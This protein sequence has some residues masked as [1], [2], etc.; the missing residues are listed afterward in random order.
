MGFNDSDDDDDVDSED[1]S[2]HERCV[3][4]PQRRHERGH[5]ARI[6]LESVVQYPWVAWSGQLGS[7][8]MHGQRWHESGQCCFIHARCESSH[9]PMLTYSGH[10]DQRS[11]QRPRRIRGNAVPTMSSRTLETTRATVTSA[12]EKLTTQTK[13]IIVLNKRVRRRRAPSPG[14]PGAVR[15][16]A[17]SFQPAL[18]EN[19]SRHQHH[20]Q[21][22][23]QHRRLQRS[24]LGEECQRKVNKRARSRRWGYPHH[25]AAKLRSRSAIH[26]ESGSCETVCSR[27]ECVATGDSSYRQ[28]GASARSL[29]TSATCLRQWNCL[30]PPEL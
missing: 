9:R 2:G 28:Q 18:A 11:R 8:S 4:F 20:Q 23:V 6:R 14:P 24:F 25:Q 10:F 19:A 22:R 15:D 1:R 12:S 7:W 26:P 29:Q 21:E 17:I 5:S 3:P 27:A 13:F 30:R 16:L